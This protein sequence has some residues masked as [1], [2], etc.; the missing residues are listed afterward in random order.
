[1]AVPAR[2]LRLA[3]LFVALGGTLVGHWLM[4]QRAAL[5]RQCPP[6]QLDRRG[7]RQQGQP[8]ATPTLTA[9]R[10]AAAQIDSTV[11][12]PLSLGR[13][14][15]QHHGASLHL[16]RCASHQRNTSSLHWQLLGLGPRLASL[17]D[18]ERRVLLQAT[19]PPV[20]ANATASPASLRPPPNSCLQR[21]G[22]Q[23]FV[24]VHNNN[25]S[26]IP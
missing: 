24:Q 1:M 17:P 19:P 26:L 3:I 18:G 12:V 10:A 23:R 25:H 6:L 11:L 7:E 16:G 5:A 20:P 14:C 4:L 21:R 13:Q 22:E 8:A 2:V 15:L 9:A